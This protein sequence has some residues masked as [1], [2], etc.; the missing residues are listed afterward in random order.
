MLPRVNNNNNNNNNNTDVWTLSNHWKEGTCS[1]QMSAL[2]CERGAFTWCLKVSTVEKF[3][4]WQLRSNQNE[5]VEHSQSITEYLHDGW[6]IWQLTWSTKHLNE[7][8]STTEVC[9]MHLPRQ[10]SAVNRQQRQ[11]LHRLAPQAGSQQ[12]S[13]KHSSLFFQQLVGTLVGLTYP[14]LV[15]LRL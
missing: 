4:I 1:H 7:L 13:S 6:K 14:R 11:L 3:S 2:V 15:R 8:S 12:S 5:V 10:R 9:R